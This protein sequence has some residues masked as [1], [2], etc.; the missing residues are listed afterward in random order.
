ML[1]FVRAALKSYRYGLE[2]PEE[3]AQVLNER[4]PT[5][6]PDITLGRL[7][8]LEELAVGETGGSLDAIGTYEDAKLE[9]ALGWA[10][11]AFDKQEA[12]EPGDVVLEGFLGP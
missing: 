11:E 8:T 7:S 6:L 2:N 4:F 9:A 5:L 10:E 3:A 1:R 12:L